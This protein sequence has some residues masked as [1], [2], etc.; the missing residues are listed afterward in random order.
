MS[1]HWTTIESHHAK[2]VALDD[3]TVCREAAEWLDL[4]RISVT[5]ADNNLPEYC[6]HCSHCYGKTE[7]IE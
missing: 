4:E 5:V 1:E 6:G 7:M 3:L 2:Q